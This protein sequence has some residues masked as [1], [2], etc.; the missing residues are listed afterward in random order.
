MTAVIN[1]GVYMRSRRRAILCLCHDTDVLQVRGML[2]EHFGY[3]VLS[4]SS[5][6]DAKVAAKDSSRHAADGQQLSR[7]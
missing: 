6:E 5:V 4:T 3:Q 2:L 7:H 1:P